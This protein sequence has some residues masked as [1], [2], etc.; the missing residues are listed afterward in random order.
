MTTKL[1]GKKLTKVSKKDLANAVDDGNGV[2]YSPDGKQLIK[3]I[4]MDLEKCVIKEGTE[5]IAN[6]AFHLRTGPDCKER[7]LKEVII[8]NTVTHIGKG[9]FVACNRIKRMVLPDS[10]T[11]LGDCTFQACDSMEEIILPDTLAHIGCMA[12]HQCSSL[13][14]IVIPKKAR[15]INAA[16]FCNCPNLVIES[17]SSRFV[18]QDGFLID[19][20][21]KT[22]FHYFG[23]EKV[24]TMPKGIVRIDWPVFSDSDVEEVTI[25]D[26]VTTLGFRAFNNCH[27]LRKVMLPSTIKEVVGWTFTY[28]ESLC[29]I[30]VPKG[31]KEAYQTMMQEAVAQANNE[32]ESMLSYRVFRRLNLDK[33]KNP[34]EYLSALLPVKYWDLLVEV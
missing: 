34:E 17:R 1:T 22:P 30:C 14:H 29:E 3:L 23:K 18:V 12:F 24:V 19:S 2:L 8:P 5:V 21:R 11:Y 32:V 9:A 27:S 16:A 28:C 31:C 13:K 26:T 20:K 10:V 33:Y 4:N 6:E 25:P 7:K 15:Y